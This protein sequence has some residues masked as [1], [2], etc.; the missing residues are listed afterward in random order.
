MLADFWN[1]AMAGNFGGP[2][3]GSFAVSSM[4]SRPAPFRQLLDNVHTGAGKCRPGTASAMLHSYD[5]IEN[6]G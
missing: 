3:L 2:D 4:S 5:W 6:G 1:L